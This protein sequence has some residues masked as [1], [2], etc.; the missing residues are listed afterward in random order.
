[1]IGPGDRVVGQESQEVGLDL[2]RADSKV[3]SSPDS[4]VP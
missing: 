4:V 1:M 2:L 3:K